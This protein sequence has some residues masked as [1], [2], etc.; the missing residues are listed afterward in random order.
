VTTGAGGLGK[1]IAVSTGGEAYRGPLG[2]YGSYRLDRVSKLLSVTG[3]G[4]KAGLGMVL[5]VDS[6][7]WDEGRGFA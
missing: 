6:A 3:S 4:E 1:G 7:R 5:V 2:R